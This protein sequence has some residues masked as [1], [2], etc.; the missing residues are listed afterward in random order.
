MVPFASR[1]LEYS[2]DDID[3]PPVTLINPLDGLRQFNPDISLSNRV[4]PR[5]HPFT[6]VESDR[7]RFCLSILRLTCRLFM[8]DRRV[9]SYSAVL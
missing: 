7:R 2:I 3:S 9:V 6:W 8:K 5:D 4:Y 1:V